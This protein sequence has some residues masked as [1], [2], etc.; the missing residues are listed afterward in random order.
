MGTRFAIAA[1]CESMLAA[2]GLDSMDAAFAMRSAED[3]SKAG[4]EGWRQRLRLQLSSPGGQPVTCYLKRF[5]RPPLRRQFQRWLQGH[6]GLSTAGV[7]WENCEALRRAGI[8]AACG[9]AFGE[10]MRGPVERR[11]FVLLG[12]VAGESLEKW[13]PRELSP[14]RQSP[15]ERQQSTKPQ[16]ALEPERW[17]LLRELAE[18]VGRFHAAGF[19]HRD[20]YLSHI[21]IGPPGAQGAESRDFRATRDP[22]PTGWMARSTADPRSGADAGRG[23]RLELEPRGREGRFCL[24]DLQRVFRPKWRRRRWVIKDLASLEFSTPADCISVSERLRFLC[25]YAKVCPGL[26]SPREL[27]A[28]IASKAARIAAHHAKRIGRV[29]AL[30]RARRLERTGETPVPH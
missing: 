10:R 3:L 5:D 4:L 23:G 15:A 6:P 18:F 17:A 8:S 2:N 7:E 25:W 29:R 9:M 14:T 30:P 20:L 22:R 27:A 16:A 11:S 24:I 12:E 26:G 21:F 1:G 13:V 28:R 19:V